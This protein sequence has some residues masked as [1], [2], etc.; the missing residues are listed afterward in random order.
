MKDTPAI[1]K[2]DSADAEAILALQ[3]LAYKDEAKIYGDFQIPPLLETLEEV[4]SKFATHLI[5]KASANG[6]LVG[7]VRAH[8]AEGTCHISRL[9]VHPDFQNR[10]IATQLLLETEQCFP[11]CRRFELFTGERS[12]KN[13]RLYE[14]L[15]YKR[16][17]VDSRRVMCGWFTWRKRVNRL[18]Y[19]SIGL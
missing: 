3:K 6:K 18:V 2:A 7:S 16:Y 9:A 15:G 14:K 4:R 17:R 1:E 10:G 12:L 11:L 13:I 19:L 5:L 8:S